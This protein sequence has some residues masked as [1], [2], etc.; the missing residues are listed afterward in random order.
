M[1]QLEDLKTNGIAHLVEA[2]RRGSHTLPQSM[3]D[4]YAELEA[5]AAEHADRRGQVSD[6]AAIKQA[7]KLTERL[8]AAKAWGNATTLL[9]DHVQPALDTFLAQLA[10]DLKTAGR[11]ADQPG[12]TVDM[13]DE[14]DDVRAAIIRLHGALVPYGH[15]RASWQILRRVPAIEVHDPMGLNSP[16]AEVGNLPDIVPDWEAAYHGR[17]PWPW[18]STVF[19]IRMKWL[20][21]HGAVVWLPTEAEHEDAWRHY[22]PAALIREAA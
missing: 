3:L 7:D 16:L 2:A 6:A 12:A 10:A 13:L 22:N 14:P 11:H 18:P 5:L 4:D 8:L 17:K 20:L 1:Q 9:V 21:S 19:H 15:L